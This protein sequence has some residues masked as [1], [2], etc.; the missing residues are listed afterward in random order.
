VADASPLATFS[1]ECL[2]GKV[3]YECVRSV[4][5]R[6]T[7]LMHSRRCTMTIESVHISVRAPRGGVHAGRHI[8]RSPARVG[9][10]VLFCMSP[11]YRSRAVLCLSSSM[12]LIGASLALLAVRLHRIPSED[13]AR[14]APAAFLKCCSPSKEG[15]DSKPAAQLVE[16]EQGVRSKEQQT[17][18]Q[19]QGTRLLI[20]SDR[21][22][23]GA[24]SCF[25]ILRIVCSVLLFCWL[26]KIT[27]ALSL[28]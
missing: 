18:S 26:T 5:E 28:P 6:L 11:R 3:S 17:Q 1:G 7:V 27:G 15:C 9:V 24:R 12:K 13:S 2:G 4:S 21:N 10:L 22:G 23:R 20:A 16:E 19:S 25:R 8:S 14:S